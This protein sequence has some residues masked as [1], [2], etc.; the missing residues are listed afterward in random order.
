MTR[1]KNGKLR[2]K[3]GVWDPLKRSSADKQQ[4]DVIPKTPQSDS[5]PT[6]LPMRI[7]IF[8][9]AKSCAPSGF[10]SNF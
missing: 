1:L 4:A 2:R 6:G 10:N 5:H 9:A 7:W 3:D 8:S